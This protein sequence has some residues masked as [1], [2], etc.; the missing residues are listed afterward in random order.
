LLI[1]VAAWL[2]VGLILLATVLLVGWCISRR[3][4]GPPFTTRILR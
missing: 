1:A 4:Q 3:D 2:L